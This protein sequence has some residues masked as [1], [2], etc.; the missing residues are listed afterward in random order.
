MSLLTFYLSPSD[1]GLIQLASGLIKLFA[2][3]LSLGTPQYLMT[4]IYD[5]NYTE[6]LKISFSSFIV[7]SFL[8]SLAS[9]FILLSLYGFRM[10]F[11]NIPTQH[12]WYLPLIGFLTLSFEFMLS[13]LIFK[14]RASRYIVTNT[15][16]V[17][18][19][20]VFIYLL[21]MYFQFGWTGRIQAL[22]ISLILSIVLNYKFFVST[23]NL[24][25]KSVSLKAFLHD[26]KRGLPL[27]VLGFS[28]LIFDISD[29]FFLEKM[30]GLRETG[31]YSVAYT[32]SSIV[33]IIG[34]A[35]SNGISP[36]LYQELSKEHFSI[37]KLF[38]VTTVLIIA[39]CLCIYI[40][41]GFVFQHLFDRQYSSAKS[42][43]L[44][45]TIGFLF[46]S[47]YV[48]FNSILVF[49]N[50][51]ILVAKISF[52]GI[53][54][55]LALNYILIKMMGLIGA[56]IATMLSCLFLLACSLFFSY[57]Q[58]YRIRLKKQHLPTNMD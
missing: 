55:N 34:G 22:F 3:C 10:S 54:I 52:I 42:L 21:V 43:V 19:E 4:K 38:I 28:I 20:F 39:V 41:S 27:V 32:Y 13:I 23:S 36:K 51:N 40:M 6:K 2:V 56:S 25:S 7:F 53:F 31:M 58:I 48:F 15:L 8:A 49:Y 24:F 5:P 35:I 26:S 9:A 11:F 30:L 45:M 47:M 16:K 37:K 14:E 29:R 33:L 18:A 17:C 46:W 12:L 1:Y 57:Q 44:S 50:K